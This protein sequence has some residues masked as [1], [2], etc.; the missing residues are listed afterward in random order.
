MTYLY[1]GNQT[2]DIYDNLMK[3][4]GELSTEP[5]VDTYFKHPERTFIVLIGEKYYIRNKSTSGFVVM[6]DVTEQDICVEF[7]VHAGGTGIFNISYEA[8]SKLEKE[9]AELLQE[10]GFQKTH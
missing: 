3:Q 2:W 7:K 1:Q 4:L 6:M 10:I 5:I 8:H 9:I